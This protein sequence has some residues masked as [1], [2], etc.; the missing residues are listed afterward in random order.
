MLFVD[1]F[2]D[3]QRRGARLVFRP[4]GRLGGAACVSGGG[5]YEAEL[6]R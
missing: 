3:N 4:G 5:A 1:F 6:G 2:T